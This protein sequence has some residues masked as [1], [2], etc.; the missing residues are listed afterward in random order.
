MATLV[1]DKDTGRLVRESTGLFGGD[2]EHGLCAPA[3]D[4]LARNKAIWTER[5][6]LDSEERSALHA[7][8]ILETSLAMRW[9]R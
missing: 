6:R 8:W 1:M 4:E 3:Q 9:H 7:S 5:P 2:I